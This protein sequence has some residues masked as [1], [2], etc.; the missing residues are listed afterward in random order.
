MFF[1]V[2]SCRRESPW[3][4]LALRAFATVI[5]FWPR[6]QVTKNVSRSGAAARRKKMDFLCIEALPAS[7]NLDLETDTQLCDLRVLCG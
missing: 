1:A 7:L 5:R 4:L 2:S 3:L 6:A